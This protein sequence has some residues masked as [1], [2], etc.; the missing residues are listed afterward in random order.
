MQDSEV[1]RMAEWF[2]L[3][4]CLWREA[5][6]EPI[7]GKAAVAD[8]I[9]TRAADSRWPDSV[10]GV[11]TQRW[12]F[13]AFNQSDPNVTK[14][15]NP[16]GSAAEWMAFVECARVAMHA[17]D[18]PPTGRAD[19]YHAKS[20]APFPKWTRQM[21]RVGVVGNHVFY[22]SKRVETTEAD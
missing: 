10:V 7:E 4:L 9:L 16:R 12:Q 17:L 22:D 18:K 6:G 13:S 14:F 20:M 19:H 3:A 2:V 11:I 1:E 5:R 15:P 21:Q 8:V